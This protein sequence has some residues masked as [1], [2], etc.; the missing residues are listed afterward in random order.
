MQ[1]HNLIRIQVIE[2]SSRYGSD[3]Y[4]YRLS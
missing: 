2:I 3:A 1:N 4:S